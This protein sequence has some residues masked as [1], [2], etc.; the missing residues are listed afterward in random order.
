MN[1]IP[2]LKP[3]SVLPLQRPK[4]DNTH[5][6]S[7]REWLDDNANTLARY[8]RECGQILGMTESDNA[9][10]DCWLHVQHDIEVTLQRRVEAHS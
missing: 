3:V 5:I 8:W 1:A 7:Y 9:D 10:F 6:V 2:I 4:F